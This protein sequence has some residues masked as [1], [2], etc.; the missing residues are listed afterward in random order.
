MSAMIQIS[1]KT[2]NVILK[3]IEKQMVLCE[4]IAED[5]SFEW[6]HHGISFTVWKV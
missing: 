6:S 2:P 3:I 4:N 1:R 5:V